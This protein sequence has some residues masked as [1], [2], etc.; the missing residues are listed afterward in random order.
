ML[1]TLC[2]MGVESKFKQ[3]RDQKAALASLPFVRESAGSLN[4]TPTWHLSRAHL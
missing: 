1:L 2:D 4:N 3:Q